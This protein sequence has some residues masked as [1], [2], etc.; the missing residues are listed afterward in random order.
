MERMRFIALG[1]PFVLAC[2]APTSVSS[3]DCDD[4][5][6]HV[7]ACTGE[8][9]V[10]TACDSE[11]AQAILDTPCSELTVAR[12]DGFWSKLLCG[13]GLKSHCPTAKPSQSASQAG[14]GEQ[15]SAPKPALYSVH[16]TVFKV[17]SFERIS[18]AVVYLRG[19]DLNRTSITT[20]DGVFLFTSVPPGSYDLEVL[21]QRGYRQTRTVAVD[22]SSG[23]NV[24]YVLN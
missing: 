6:S 16:G 4:A 2:S 19:K 21:S 20:G 24:L 10:P 15:P 23:H 13:F 17:G 11:T 5:A 3:S 18:A 1:L 22:S 12:A 8:A 14:E 7:I 9:P